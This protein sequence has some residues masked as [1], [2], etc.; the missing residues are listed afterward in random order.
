VELSGNSQRRQHASTNE[1]PDS[2]VYPSSQGSFINNGR[3]EF[4]RLTHLNVTSRPP[5]RVLHVLNWFRQ[6]GLETQVLR[7][8]RCYDRQHFHM[9]ACVI[10][11]EA[12]YLAEEAR[13][14][15]AEILSCPKSPNLFSFSRLFFHMLRNRTYDVVHSHG[16]AWS[17]AT[18]RGAARAGVPVRIA[19]MR[20]MGYVGAEADKNALIKAA[21]VVVTGWGRHWVRRHATHVVAVSQATLDERWPEW[22][23][24]SDRF[25]VW[26]AG[27]DTQRFSAVPNGK[28]SVTAPVIICVGNFF[29]RS[30]R[31]DLAVRVLASVRR[32][33]PEARLVFVGTGTHESA[34]R[35]LAQGLG[36]SEAVDF[37]G[38]R[39]RTEI[40]VLLR[41]ARVFLYCSE[42]E[43]LPNVLLE[44]QATGLPVV[45]TDIPAHR[46]VLSPAL[47]PYLFNPGELDQ[48]A[49][50][51]AQILTESDLA[52]ALGGAGRA[53]V[54][55]HYNS[56][57]CLKALEDYY[58][59]WLNSGKG[60][61]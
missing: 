19:H 3:C 46:E 16:E 61:Q 32:T 2:G 55:K 60:R 31:Q 29:L 21:R 26:T 33:V 12:G 18:L 57:S 53:Y 41:S 9:D 20:D 1:K 30:K 38:P 25:L 24:R 35:H 37:L 22:R 15:G 47:H 52:Q 11:A 34:C 13:S 10:G 28:S 40:P 6:G 51:I 45:A 56:S 54:T 27:V 42:S 49:T 17:G 4:S 39:D 8:L 44:A 59:S 5:I 7:I 48:A 58:V 43:G 23:R 50:R 36:V 14:Y